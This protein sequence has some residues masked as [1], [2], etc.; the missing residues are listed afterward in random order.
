MECLQPEPGWLPLLTHR[1]SWRALNTF[2]SFGSSGALTK[3]LIKSGGQ[4]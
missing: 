3:E 1:V 2:L 4:A